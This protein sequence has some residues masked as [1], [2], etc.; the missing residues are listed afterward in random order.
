MNTDINRVAAQKV[1]EAIDSLVE[2]ISD[3]VRNC[4]GKKLTVTMDYGEI[5]I[6]DDVDD[7]GQIQTYNED[8]AY[9]R[10][11]GEYSINELIDINN[12]IVSGNFY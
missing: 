7:T 6:F 1:K 4:D 3:T 12:Q 8:F 11:I 10:N 2:A 9:Y 5:T